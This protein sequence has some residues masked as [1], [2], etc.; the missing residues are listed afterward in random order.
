MR[1][2]YKCPKC[3]ASLG[4]LFTDGEMRNNTEKT[5]TCQRGGSPGGC[6][7]LHSVKPTDGIPY[8]PLWRG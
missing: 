3:G 8:A 4:Y 6:G 1:I 2:A 5:A 7:E